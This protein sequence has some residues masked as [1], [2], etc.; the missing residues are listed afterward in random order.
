VARELLAGP[1]S[2]AR[3]P[4]SIRRAAHAILAQPEFRSIPPSVV[5]RV[6]HWLGQQASKLL[7][8]TLS[9]HL[10]VIG[11]G[12]LVLIVGLLVWLVVRGVRNLR[13]DPAAR[14]PAVAST[15]RPPADWLAEASACEARGDWRGGLRA[16]YRALVAELSRRGLVDEI[17]GRTT[18]EY[19]AEVAA[20]L[21]GAAVEFGTATD[22]FEA[23][24]YGHRSAGPDD[25]NEIRELSAR[26][27]E[28]AR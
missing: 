5:D 20:H 22:L 16:R 1:A 2:P 3:D 14:G 11:A 25:T 7:D 12:V 19:R 8:E 10:S 27:L 21:P 15:R 24:V 28:G 13:A 4:D 23:A 26:V 6:R 9:G 18:G 17:P